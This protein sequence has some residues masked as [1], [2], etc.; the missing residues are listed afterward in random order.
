MGWWL[1]LQEGTSL[2]KHDRHTNTH[3]LLVNT[4]ALAGVLQSSQLAG[5]RQ[6]L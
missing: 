3:S 2:Y 4:H 1:E 6:D 5:S